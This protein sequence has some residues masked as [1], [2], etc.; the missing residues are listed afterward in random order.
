MI[1]KLNVQDFKLDFLP[2]VLEPMACCRDCLGL[3][4]VR[5]VEQFAFVIA[6]DG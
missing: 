1:G 2:E 6:A 5:C 3:R 4:V